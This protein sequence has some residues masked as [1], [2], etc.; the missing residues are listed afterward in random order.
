VEQT[1]DGGYLLAGFTWSFGAGLA[2]VYLVKTDSSGGELWSNS[3]GTPF[4]D[5]GFCA[6][7]TSDG[8]YVVAGMT[9]WTATGYS[10]VYLIKVDSSGSTV[11]DTT[12]GGPW[13]DAAYSVQ[14]TADGG[15]F[16]VGA[17]ESFGAG[18]GDVY[19]VKTDS[20]GNVL[21]DRTY[22]GVLDDCGLWG[23]Q[24]ADSGYVI[25][26]ITSSFGAGGVDYYLLKTDPAGVVAW[27]TTYGGVLDD[28]CVCGQQTSDAGYVTVGYTK[29]FG[30]GAEDVWIVKTDSLGLP[31]WDRTF[32]GSSPDRGHSIQQT[33]DSGYVITGYTWSFGA[34]H[35]DVYVIKTDQDGLTGIEKTRTESA[36]SQ[37]SFQLFQ[38][39]PNP[40][41]LSTAISYSLPT[42]AQVTLSIHDITGRLVETLVNE[43]QQPGI[44]Q[45]QWD[46]K[47]NPSGVYFYRLKAGEFVETRKM[48]V[49][50]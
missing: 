36:L 11:W 5:E 43:P 20:L 19:A 39:L 2:D 14:L 15:Y 31:M 24:T 25:G 9:S 3:Y 45:V 47:T 29:S 4:F 7:E 21:W 42:A 46:R 28:E 49:I 17:T 16:L 44:H 18:G 23:H 33:L 34:G 1:T 41:H 12:Y 48:V 32:G 10:D 8:G 22:G 35:Y 6:R 38:N 26:G 50:D 37:R 13:A 27:D 40:L 30:A